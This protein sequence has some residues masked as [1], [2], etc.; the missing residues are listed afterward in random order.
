MSLPFSFTTTYL[1]DKSHFEECFEES[2]VAER[3]FSLYFKSLILMVFGFYFVIATAVEPY[4][5]W[6][7][8]V[9]GFVDGLSVYYRKPWWV[10]RQM[11]S[12][13]AGTQVTLSMNEQSVKSQS[14]I[15]ETEILWS[16]VVSMQK[17]RQGWLLMHKAGKNYISSSCLTEDA[18]DF[19]VK[20]SELLSL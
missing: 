12:K 6:F 4:V 17:S 16:D 20:K 11:L 19:L 15:I 5:A 10:G 7:M 8:V 9:L 1:L 13:A 18:E 3:S 2:V 14:P